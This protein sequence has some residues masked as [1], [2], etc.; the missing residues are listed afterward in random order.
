MISGI[1]VSKGIALGKA[2][3]INL[4][5]KNIKK[6][7]IS[8]KKIK[9]EIKKFLKSIK[10]SVNQIKKIKKYTEKKIGKDKSEI[11]EGHIMIL[12][13]DELS[14]DII[15][16]IN[17]KYTAEISTKKVIKK[18]IKK[19]RKIKNKYLKNRII[20]IKDIGKRIIDN[21]L[22]VNI[23]KLSKIDK[24]VILICKDLT[25]SETSEINKKNILGF[26]TELG[27]ETSHTSIIAKSLGI[28]AIVGVKN[29]TKQVKNKDFIILDSINNEI[30]INPNKEIITL[31]KKIK[32]NF[33]KNKQKLEIFKNLKAITL[34][35]KK[36]KIGAN[37]NKIDDICLAKKN[38]AQSIGLYRTEFLYMGKNR[39]PTEEE[40][41]IVYKKIIEKMKN[42]E[43][44]MRTLDIGGDKS[45]KYLNLPKEENPF[46]GYRAI[47]IYSKKINII[48][49]QLR[50]MLRASNFGKLKIMFPMIISL[51]EI[52]FLKKEL[53]RAKKKL[54]EENISFNKNIKIGIMIE[55]PAA[56]LISDSLSKEVDFFSIGS[57]DL[58]QY[59]L[60]VDRGNDL[61]SHLY[62]PMHP[63]V[64]KLIKMV[65]KS[66]HK[67]GKWTGICGELASNPLATKFLIKIGID[68][69]SINSPEIPNIKK[70]IRK[71]YFKKKNKTF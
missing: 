57:N 69:F 49:T 41:F 7:K 33:F 45:C 14:K 1:I 28:P 11:F 46:L 67:N 2:L 4:Y 8:K 54:K 21:I 50:A 70:I 29:I 27:G 9:L 35:G 44:I 20:D 64:M 3:L 12:Q 30:Y 61:V 32:K 16:Y 26:I 51:E 36:I 58:T 39:L 10:K 19:M 31:K 25:P 37:I 65:V 6:E 43:V 60:A 68:E 55:T 18:Q 42:K 23:K 53:K 71:S 47:R 40:Q 66:S 22:N 63:S 24:K 62:D 38:G 59:T 17:K 15:N 34:D 48:R 56:A 52:Y 5:K 13:D